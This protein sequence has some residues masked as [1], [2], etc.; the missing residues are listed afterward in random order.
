MSRIY[1]LV[2]QA[3]APLKKPKQQTFT[4]NGTFNVPTGVTT[5]YV[6]ATA[7][8][9]AG[10]AGSGGVNS[11]NADGGAGGKGGN[12]GQGVLDLPMAVTPGEAI[13][14]TVGAGNTIFKALTLVKGLGGKGGNGGTPGGSSG[15]SSSGA[16]GGQGVGTDWYGHGN[17]SPVHKSNYTGGGGAGG[18]G[19]ESVFGLMKNYNVGSGGPGANYGVMVA[20]SAGGAGLVYG[21]GGAGGGGTSGG[22]GSQPAAAAGGAGGAGCLIVRW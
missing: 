10:T 15:S 5:V 2:M 1:G 21:Q 20:G 12:G 16:D 17:A 7:A 3:I 18:A 4:A 9:D 8:G 6:T 11:T 19:G 13:S 22:T 14:V